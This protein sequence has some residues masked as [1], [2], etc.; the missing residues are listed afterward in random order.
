MPFEL[1]ASGLSIQSLEEIKGELEVD[2]R[3][4][5]GQN[6]DLDADSPFGQLIGIWAE[7]EAHVQQVTLLVHN[8]NNPNTAI[9]T[10]LDAEASITATFRKDATKSLSA[11]GLVTGTPATVVDDTESVR[12]VQTGDLWNIV[13]GPYVIPGGGSIAVS[14]EADETGPKV[15][16]TTDPVDTDPLGWAIETPVAGWDTFETTADIDPEDTGADVEADALLRTRREDELFV[17]G[18][19]NSA[20]KANVLK[21]TG[22]T[23]VKVIDNPNCLAVVDGIPGGAFETIVDGGA[24]AAIAD[25]IFEKRPPGAE[26]F[27]TIITPLPDGE[28]GTVDIGHTRPTDVDIYIIITLDTT[29]AEGVLPA[30]AAQLA[31]D[32]FLAE[33]ALR[34]VEIGADFVPKSYYGVIFAAV[35]NPDSDLDTVTDVTVAADIAP[36]PTLEDPIPITIR[37]RADFDSANTSVVVV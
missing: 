31:E 1:T 20:I 28:G 21:V 24:D 14:I 23:Q 7:R 33:V 36:A 35:R 34:G 3:T 8:Q 37:E 26:S 2:F 18:N 12:L 29:G 9:G 19:D 16:Q 22:V 5:F 30:N 17:A 10:S 32:A 15:F 27:G 13:G 11:S 6:V 25:A 4:A